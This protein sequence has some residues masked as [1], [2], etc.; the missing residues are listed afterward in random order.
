MALKKYLR[1]ALILTV[2]LSTVQ[3]FRESTQI[4]AAGT[5]NTAIN[6]ADLATASTVST[7]YGKFARA[8]Q[9]QQAEQYQQARVLYDELSTSEEVGLAESARFNLA[10]TYLQ[11][12]VAVDIK[13]DADIAIPLVELA[14]VAYRQLL[15]LS[16]NHWGGK[17]NLER[18]LQLS[19]DSR[20]LPLNEIPGRRAPN[21]TVISIDPEDSLP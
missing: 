3:I 19:P 21:R 11:Q 13:K 1:L 15:Q 10:N 7:D 8:Y 6:Q 12:A 4:W 9:H 2:V 17:Y 16:P 20:A 14:K 5:Y 18:A